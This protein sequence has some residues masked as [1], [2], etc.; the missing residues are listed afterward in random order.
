MHERFDVVQK[1]VFYTNVF[2][3]ICT[4]TQFILF[5]HA[6]GRPKQQTC[7]GGDACSDFTSG[8]KRSFP[9]SHKVGILSKV[10]PFAVSHTVC[11]SLSTLHATVTCFYKDLETHT[12]AMPQIHSTLRSTSK[13]LEK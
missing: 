10:I 9:R 2:S 5:L 1:Y 13:C 8:G 12:N 6:R 4:I 11:C 7:K 3:S